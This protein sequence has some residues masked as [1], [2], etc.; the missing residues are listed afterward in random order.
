MMYNY[1]QYELYQIGSPRV[2]DLTYLVGVF[3]L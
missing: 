1:G 2:L 3:S